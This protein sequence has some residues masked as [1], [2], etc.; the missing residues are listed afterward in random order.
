VRAV[1]KNVLAVARLESRFAMTFNTA[2]Q[3]ALPPSKVSKGSVLRPPCEPNG[4]QF[5]FYT[6]KHTVLHLR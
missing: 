1:E 6:C 4:P 5:G 3:D 2:P